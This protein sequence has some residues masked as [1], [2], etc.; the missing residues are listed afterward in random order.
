MIPGFLDALRRPSCF[1]T[2]QPTARTHLLHVG[3]AALLVLISIKSAWPLGQSSLGFGIAGGVALALC[4]RYPGIGAV[5]GVAVA[6]SAAFLNDGL[7]TLSPGIV[8]WL[9]AAVLIARGHHR[10]PAYGSVILHMMVELVVMTRVLPYGG[11]LED[12]TTQAF[13]GGVAL[14]VGELSRLPRHQAEDSI[15]AH[16]S[17][18]ERQ[19]IL[20]VSEL[21]DTVVRD[22]THAVMTAEQVRLAHP[23]NDLL[24]RE[25]GTMIGS[26]RTS[27]EQLRHS[28]RAIRDLRGEEHLDLL[29]TEAPRPLREVVAE[30]GETLGRRGVDLVVEGIDVFDG[31]AIPPGIRVQLTRVLGE[32]VTNTTKYAA[33]SGS[34]R[35]VVESDGDTVEALVS[36]DVAASPGKDPATSSGLGLE[37]ARRRIESL[38]GT[39]DVT[40]TP[41]RWT[42]VLSI[43]LRPA[44]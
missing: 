23:E 43:P 17:E 36:N 28:L 30:A 26:V 19:R 29:A 39:F 44:L 27:V 13:G 24:V 21:H 5:A 42:V 12:L 41:S 34:A 32:L 7:P 20:V 31:T 8:P 14:L 10:G 35:I 40:R 15:L 38:G 2:W 25:L 22:L 4:S 16:R 18:L 6:W 3:F 9:C 33:P 11:W 1:S 37:G